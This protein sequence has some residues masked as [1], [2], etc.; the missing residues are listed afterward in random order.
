ML[1]VYYYYGAI[2]GRRRPPF[3]VRPV[4]RGE[5]F[6][7]LQQTVEPSGGHFETVEKSRLS[8]NTECFRGAPFFL[9]GPL[10]ERNFHRQV[11]LNADAFM[12]DVF[13]NGSK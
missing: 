13:Y 4:Y 6:R 12:R 10:R 8:K 1:G 7:S 9:F 3:R 11:S 2:R 5:G